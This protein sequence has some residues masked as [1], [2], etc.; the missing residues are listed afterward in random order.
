MTVVGVVVGSGV[1]LGYKI[2][3]GLGAALDDCSIDVLFGV[4]ICGG[5]HVSR[6]DGHL[7]VVVGCVLEWGWSAGVV[8]V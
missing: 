6:C 7:V 1:V 3:F 2:A 5:V 4:V 8:S